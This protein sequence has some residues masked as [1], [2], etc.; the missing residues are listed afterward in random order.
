MYMISLVHTQGTA[1]F[2]QESPWLGWEEHK[3]FL[4][5][6]Q[7][8][9]RQEK[10]NNYRQGNTTIG[11]K[12]T[13]VIVEKIQQF[14]GLLG[15]TNHGFTV[16]GVLMSEILSVEVLSLEVCKLTEKERK[17]LSPFITSWSWEPHESC[18]FLESAEKAGFW[19]HPARRA[20]RKPWI[21]WERWQIRIFRTSCAMN[22]VKFQAMTPSVFF[23]CSVC[24]TLK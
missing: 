4:V 16:I 7:K 2:W 23:N 14:N 15:P 8:G 19:E 13:V 12:N 3:N 24:S 22:A 10:H 17:E 18:D 5:E 6:K 21:I 9:F 11:G 20:P 1:D